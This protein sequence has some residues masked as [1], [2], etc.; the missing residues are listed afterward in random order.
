MSDVEDAMFAESPYMGLDGPRRRWAALASVGLEAL[1]VG[2]LLLVPL[3]YTQSLPHL[4]SSAPLTMPVIE[5]A[6][7]P[8]EHTQPRTPAP[9]SN[10]SGDHLITPSSIPHTVQNIQETVAPPQVDFNS[11][12]AGTGVRGVP[13]GTGLFASNVPVSPP[14]VPHPVIVSRMMEGYLTQQV[15][16]IYPTAAKLLHLQGQ[17]VVQAIISREGTIE[18]MQ[19]LSGNALLANAARQAIAQWRYRPYKLNGEAVEV[20]T[21]I[22]VNFVMQ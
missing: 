14:P 15:Q 17:V 16:P 5:P 19:V 8:P 11:V 2:A 21:Q 20:E 6:Q 4:L 22:T 7:T 18:H 10:L 12:A 3:I 1:M 13:G 9:V